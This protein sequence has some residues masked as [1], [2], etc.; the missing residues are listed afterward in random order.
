MDENIAAVHQ[1]QRDF[2]A[3]GFAEIEANA[4]LVAIAGEK[5]GTDAVDRD[6]TSQPSRIADAYGLDLD[7]V[8]PHVGEHLRAEGAEDEARQVQHPDAVERFGRW[9][10]T[11]S[12][13]PFELPELSFE[14]SD[15][16]IEDLRSICIHAWP[17]FCEDTFVRVQSYVSVP[18]LS[19]RQNDVWVES[20]RLRSQLERELC[21]PYTTASRGRQAGWRRG[22]YLYQYLVFCAHG[23]FG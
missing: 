13:L 14:S 2:L 1:A 11:L 12:P 5:R 17:S 20:G 21:A 8:R 16:C 23:L 18:S 6:D 15:T 22:I 3:G 7:D 4:A 10:G 9:S 19:G